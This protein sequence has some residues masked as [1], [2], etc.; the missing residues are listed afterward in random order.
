MGGEIM[1]ARIPNVTDEEWK[2][3]NT[4]NREIIEE[5]ISQQQTLSPATRVQYNSGL[6]IFARWILD[7][8]NNKQLTDLKPRDALRYQNWLLEKGLSSNGIKFKRACVSSLYN[9]LE[10]FY[11]QEFPLLRNIYSKAIKPP[12]HASVREKIPL[13]LEEIDLLVDELTKKKEWQHLAYLLVSYET[14]ARREEVRQLRKEIATYEKPKDKNFYITHPVRGK[15]GGAQGKVIR[16]YF[17]D[18]A[19]DVIKKWLE[20]RGNDECP[21][22]FVVKT[23]DNNASQVS[24]STFNYWCTN[25]FSP[26]LGGKAIHPHLLRSS[27]ATNLVVEEGKDIN[28]IK[29][30]LNHESAETSEIY[31]VRDD[32]EDLDDIF[33]P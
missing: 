24:A 29:Q 8:N 23:A 9:Y 2:N 3:V 26:I 27:R 6:R 28:A 10:L 13:T 1:S 14:G 19:M 22:L 21:F 17:G 20:V 16:L 25:T 11:E 5:F 15:G 7:H 32:T 30:L 12:A 33:D 18:K 4:F 31:V